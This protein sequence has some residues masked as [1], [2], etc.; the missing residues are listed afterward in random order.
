MKILAAVILAL[1]LVSGTTQVSAAS[2]ALTV[3]VRDDIMH[4]GYLNPNTGKY[5]GLEIDL[6]EKLAD[7][8]GY[9]QVEYVTVDP[10]NRKD[11]LLKG[12]VD[13]LIAA[14]SVSETRLENFDF[15]PGY[16]TDSSVIMAEKSTMLESM[17]DLVGKRIGALAGVNTAPKL[18]EKMIDMGLITEED[19]KGTEIVSMES[20]SDISVA[21]EEG[22]V[23]AVC[24][25]G[26]I[27]RAY[28]EDDWEILKETIGEETY[29][30]ATQK[31]SELSAKM[32]EAV[33]QLLDDGTIDALIEKWS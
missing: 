23:D 19:A 14:Y 8:L 28:M 24:M 33:Q 18:A 32:S 22:T 13:C 26:C 11:T 2:Q 4:F 16:Y 15:S 9:D 29:A 6:A 7:R 12:D 20:Y 17:S 31:N 27:S 21:L 30:V 10:D 1:G 25:D 3:G 5:Y